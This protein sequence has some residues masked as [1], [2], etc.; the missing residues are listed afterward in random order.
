MHTIPAASY[1]S[2]YF[3]PAAGVRLIVRWRPAGAARL[4]G[5]PVLVWAMICGTRRASCFRW[6]AGFAAAMGYLS[7]AVGTPAQRASAGPVIGVIDAVRLEHDQYYVVGWACQEGTRGSIDVHIYANH[8]AGDAP[9]GSFVTA[10]TANLANEPAVERACHDADGGK[11]RFRIPLSNQLLRTFQH[12]ALYAHGIAIVGNVENAAIARSGTFRFPPPAW[13]PDPRTPDFLDGPRLA[14]FDTARDSCEQIDIP[15]A[16]AR[17]FRDYAG[18]IHLIS[19]HYVTRASLGATL[20]TV[21]HNCQVVYS[22]HHDGNIA[23]F[24][25][26]TWLD[27]FYNIDGR[28]ILALG[29]MEYHGWEHAGM[30]RSKTDT[31][32]CWYN[33]DTYNLSEDGGYH[34]TRPKPPLNYFVGLPYKYE[35]NQGPEGYS[36]VANI[37]KVGGWYYDAVL[38]WSWPP[39]CGRAQ[40]QHPCL[41]PDGACLIRTADIL[42]PTTWRAWDG[43][44]FNVRFVNPYREPVTE[45]AAHVC[46]PV[47]YL[48]LSNGIN[49]HPASGLFVA[50]LWSYADFGFGPAGVYFTTSAAAH[51]RHGSRRR[52]R[53]RFRRISNGR[54]VW[55]SRTHR[56]LVMCVSCYWAPGHCT[57]AEFRSS[58]GARWWRAK[59]SLEDCWPSTRCVNSFA[60]AASCERGCLLRQCLRTLS[61][62]CVGL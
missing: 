4:H 1:T 18:T 5:K 61:S 48:D 24:D 25:D 52:N 17:A 37:L 19:S 35:V 30:C 57:C 15:D 31:F 10:G 41:V 26:A 22:S 8:A 33:V 39:N 43:H 40:G 53:V 23:D 7:M 50:I 51:G 9:A 45:P 62:R 47:P 27:S 16:A 3:D 29:H 36:V 54:C 34:F 46:A 59:D 13:P 11:H 38:S 32:S 2:F 20:E 44:E 21:K 6:I 56:P 14:A 58:D 42:D 12:K 28:R 49:F 55:Y 60:R